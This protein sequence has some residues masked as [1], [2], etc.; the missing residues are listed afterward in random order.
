MKAN[1]LRIGNYVNYATQTTIVL[2]VLRSHAELGYYSDSIGFEREYT[3]FRAIPLTEQW[4]LDFGF[5]TDN[6]SWFYS[7][8]FDDKQE[9][10]K[11]C[12]LYSN[13]VHNGMFSILNCG[14]CIK[15]VHHVH[16]LQNLFFCLCGKELEL[17]P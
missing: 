12:P 16:Q 1:E 8:D 2:D 15:K 5:Y 14:A 3:E 7:L 9:T 4:L 10:F 17:K 13:D 11:I 6:D